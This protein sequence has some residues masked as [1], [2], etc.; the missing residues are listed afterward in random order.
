M[1]ETLARPVTDV[2]RS[3]LPLSKAEGRCAR[4]LPPSF[5]DMMISSSSSSDPATALL[6]NTM[7]LPVLP[8][9][10]AAG[11]AGTYDRLWAAAS[12]L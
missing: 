4:Y 3:L 10:E 7:P 12:A 6:I 11:W 5:T 8:L 1:P 9:A 2:H